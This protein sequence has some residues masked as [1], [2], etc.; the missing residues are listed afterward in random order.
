[1]PRVSLYV[2]IKE[3]LEERKQIENILLVFYH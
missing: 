2:A 1:M 3:N